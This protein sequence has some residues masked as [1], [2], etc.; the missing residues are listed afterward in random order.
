M[1]KDDYLIGVKKEKLSNYEIKNIQELFKKYPQFSSV[2]EEY[3]K[4]ATPGVGIK[5]PIGKMKGHSYE[6][7]KRLDF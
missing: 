4:K 3:L 6:E 2:K 5:K 1:A 7:N